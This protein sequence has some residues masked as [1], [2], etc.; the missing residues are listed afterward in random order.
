MPRQR[1]DRRFKAAFG[2][3]ARRAPAVAAVVPA[4]AYGEHFATAD[5][6]EQFFR[7]FGDCRAR[8]LHQFRGGYP[9]R[10]DGV[11]IRRAHLR[12]GE[13]VLH[14]FLPSFVFPLPL[15]LL[16]APSAASASFAVS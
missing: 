9:Q 2:E 4:A 7:L 11:F 10:F 15:L 12:A 8:P 3:E 16:V 5:L 13:Y 14:T 1:V 6:A